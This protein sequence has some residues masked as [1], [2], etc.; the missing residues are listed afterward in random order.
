M[1]M[2]VCHARSSRLRLWFEALASA[3]VNVDAV[4]RHSFLTC[5][6][7]T[8]GIMKELAPDTAVHI[9]EELKELKLDGRFKLDPGSKH[10]PSDLFT[11]YLLNAFEACGIHSNES[12]FP[13]DDPNVYD[14][15]ATGVDFIPATRHDPARAAPQVHK[16][17][18][19]RRF[20]ED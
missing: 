20:E 11:L 17:P 18:R 10:Y 1:D 9:L 13:D 19:A 16:R 8:I 12:W 2:A 3:G 5:C 4:A 6:P 14:L 7:K 15:S